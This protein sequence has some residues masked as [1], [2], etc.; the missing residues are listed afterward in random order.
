MASD[1]TP[2]RD[3]LSSMKVSELRQ[4]CSERSLLVSGKKDEL[5]GRLLGSPDAPESA[6]AASTS[7][8]PE[9]IDDAID[10]LIARVSSEAPAE[11]EPEEEEAEEEVLEAEIVVTEIVEEEPEP[12]IPET[13]V[14]EPEEEDPWFSGVIPSEEPPQMFL[15][16]EDAEEPSLVITV[17]S[18][19]GLKA[20]WKPIS[21]VAVVIL[22]VGAIAFY[23]VQ[24]DH[25]FTARPLRYGDHMDFTITKTTVSITGDEMIGYLRDAVSPTLDE[26]CGELHA[27][28]TGTGSISIRKGGPGDITHGLDSD[29]EGAVSARDAY[30]REH[31]TAEQIL[32]HDLSIDLEGKVRNEGTCSNTGWIRQDND[33]TS[34]SKSWK[35]ITGKSTVRTDT[36]V[37]F[38]DSDGVRSDARSVIYGTEG[39]GV[40]GDLAPILTFPLTPIELHDF[41]GDESLE[42]GE[43]SN[44]HINWNSDWRWEVFD[45]INTAMHGL[46]YPIRIFHFEIGRCLG[47][48]IIDIQVKQGSPWPVKQEVDIVIDKDLETSDCN[49]FV[50][51]GTQAA[52]PD[53]TLSVAMVLTETSS[54]AGSIAAHW[55]T[56]YAGSPGV[57]EDIPT[58]TR[59]WGLAMPDETEIRMFDLEEAVQ[60]LMANY[61]TRDAA[62]ALDS[63]GYIWQ[64]A[65][66]EPTRSPEWN[67][68]WVSDDD[69]SGWVI[70]RSSC[71]LIGEGDYED[72]EFKWNREAVPETLTLDL[73]ET[74]ILSET[75]YPEL[76]QFIDSGA[77]WNTDVTFAHRLSV[78]EENELLGMLPGGLGEGQVTIAGSRAWEDSGRDNALSFAMNAETGR[79]VAWFHTSLPAN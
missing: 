63:G 59:Q 68:S 6:P 33:L 30:G 32:T 12:E 39:F 67:M 71:S 72:G 47:H 43:T 13:V 3:T 46:V 61:S 58:D 18:F 51:A 9:D 31:L 22:L 78:S 56:A 65:W 17:P 57:G 73:L 42:G 34:V 54:N 77:N 62:L 24:Q 75:R 53:G 20:N 50:S 74:R 1:E 4:M 36:Q 5:I 10:R 79:M 38:T 64:A 19:S 28:V 8:S 60:C 44:D 25:S 70:L 16:D 11:E 26:V 2:D 29:L 21:T 48:A 27:G 7:R 49:F 66:S 35:E 69:R 76:N 15:D 14:L 45:E 37:S 52:L 41:F 55:G 40:L 23:F